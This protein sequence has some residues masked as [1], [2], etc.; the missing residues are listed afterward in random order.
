MVVH[1]GD[2]T[3]KESP[4]GRLWINAIVDDIADGLYS[5]A[6]HADDGGL[7]FLK[8]IEYDDIQPYFNIELEKQ[9]DYGTYTV[10]I[11]EDEEDHDE[12][13]GLELAYDV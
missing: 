2:Y 11:A 7:V 3:T 9:Y 12:P 10:V 5:V 6:I 13:Y 4:S 8:Y 1:K